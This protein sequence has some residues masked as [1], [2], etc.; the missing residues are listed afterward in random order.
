M[1]PSLASP[2]PFVSPRQLAS[3]LPDVPATGTLRVLC[4]PDLHIPTKP[5]AYQRLLAHRAYLDA[6]DYVVLLGDAIRA[7]GTDR[8]YAEVKNF[9]D[10]LGRP[11]RA[12]GGNHEFWF[13]PQDEGSP[14]YGVVWDEASPQQEVAA[15]GRFQ[16][17]Y[18]LDGL[19]DA[20]RNALGTWVFLSLDGVGEWKQETLSLPQQEFLRGQIEQAGDDPLY[21][22]CHAPLMIDRPL[23]LVYYETQRSGCVELTGALALALA[24]RSGPTFWM[25]GHVHLHPEHYLFAPYEAAPRVWQVHCPDG[26]GYSRW[27]REHSV[28]QVHEGLFTRHLEAGSAGVD[29]V[30]W[31]H[32]A[33]REVA[34]YPIKF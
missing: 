26:W 4:L 13:A 30:T 20:R 25:S 32:V 9:V 8:E 24:N 29:F 6:M 28:P 18:G 15:L 19:W 7:Y 23:D 10:A 22:F 34:R 5:S 17:F 31:D 16:Q 1:T 14:H 21:I 33:D 2:P 11:Y 27:A 12:T 3:P